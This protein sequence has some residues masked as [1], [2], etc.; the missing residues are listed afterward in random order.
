MS[1][2]MGM[3]MFLDFDLHD[4]ISN[5]SLRLGLSV[6]PWGSSRT[7]A[8]LSLWICMLH[9]YLTAARARIHMHVQVPP[10]EA[11]RQDGVR[12]LEGAGR[13]PHEPLREAPREGVP[14]VEVLVLQV[15]PPPGVQEPAAHSEE[16]DGPGHRVRPHAQV[17]VVPDED[18]PQ[19][20][21]AWGATGGEMG[22][23]LCLSFLACV[24][25]YVALSRSFC[26]SASLPP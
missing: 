21:C 18:P 7:C 14:G 1:M 8:S 2:R 13:D 4:M 12:A 19:A 25:L 17:A 11:S 3:Y 16:G 24:F 23:R 26:L 20:G 5:D 22:Q 15:P 10:T 6:S 9:T